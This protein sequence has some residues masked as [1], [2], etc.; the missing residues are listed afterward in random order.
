VSIYYISTDT[1]VIERMDSYIEDGYICFQTNHFSVYAI[2]DASAPV[3]EPSG[4]DSET[5]G[6]PTF[7][8]RILEFFRRVS[9]WFKKLFGR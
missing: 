9:E 8:A 1:G 6:K 7:F 5:G 2:V 3:Q 4:T